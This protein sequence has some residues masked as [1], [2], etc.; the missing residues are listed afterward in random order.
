MDQNKYY[1]SFVS[2]GLYH[3]FNRSVGSELL[4]REERN[5]LFF[6][7]KWK[8][9]V[10]AYV[11]VFA[12]CLLPT[13]FHFFVKVGRIGNEQDVN[14]KII[15]K[16]QQLF[17]SYSLA[18]NKM[19]N[20]HGALFQK[21]FK[22]IAITNEKYFNLVVYYIHHNPIHHHLTTNFTSWKYSSYKAIIGD[23]ATEVKREIVLQWFEGKDN[24]IRFHNEYRDFNNA[25]RAAGM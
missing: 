11:D 13:H 14:S 6:L 25:Q 9:Y 2:G 22:R 8:Q 1:A 12:Y 23:G 5:Y 10:S 18:F 7:E 16:F 3:I 4:F 20:R 21:R 19:Y 15:Q 24:F 17:K